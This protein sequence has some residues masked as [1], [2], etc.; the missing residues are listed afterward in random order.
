[1][2]CRLLLL[3]LLLGVGLPGALMPAA[4]AAKDSTGFTYKYVKGSKYYRVADIAS[5]MNLRL[6]R[7]GNIYELTGSAGRMVFNPKKRY[8]S[9][10]NVVINYDF[11]PV[12]QNGE[13]YISSADFFGHVQ[14]LFNPYSL[15]KV[16]IRTILI[17]PGHGG[18]DRGA[19]GLRNNEKDLTLQI[20]LRLHRH[21]KKMGYQVYIT[22]VN[23]RRLELSERAQASN[24]IKADLFISIHMNA[25]ANRSVRGIETFSLTAVGS[26]SSGG[27]KAEYKIYPGN[28]AQNNSMYLAWHVQNNLVRATGGNDRGVKHARFVVLRETR[29]PAIL[30]ECGF[31]S[32]RTEESLL[33]S[34]AYQ[35]KLA[36]AIAR[37]IYDYHAGISQNR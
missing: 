14:V 6:R 17:D 34:G 13:L 18:N 31:I 32:N 29:C 30:I 37:G 28:A 7:V 27:D 24:S 22:R 20:A 15:R 9:F 8:G 12:V 35:E 16:G 4:Q 11:N 3:I 10:N 1:M 23:D 5:Y 36:L 33:A 2:H 25:A 21:L 26:P 19:S